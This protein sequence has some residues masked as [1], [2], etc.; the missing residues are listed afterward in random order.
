MCIVGMLRSGNF[1]PYAAVKGSAD[2]FLKMA[3][4]L[5]DD[6]VARGEDDPSS[7]FQER[8]LCRFFCS[9]ICSVRARGALCEFQLKALCPLELQMLSDKRTLRS[10]VHSGIGL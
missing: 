1:F 2:I 5:R 3:N 10:F 7:I 8:H 6:V 4:A 9:Y